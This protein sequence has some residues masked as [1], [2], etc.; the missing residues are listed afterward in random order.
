MI[1]LDT[2]VVAWAANDSKQLS[3]EA[4]SAIRRARRS[5]GLAVSGITVWELALLVSSGK[6]Q[7]YGSVETSLRLLLEG[8]TILPITP[9]I[10]ALTTQ[11]PDD[12]P[13]DPSDRLIGA[14]ARADG[15]TL[16]TR[17]ERIR[18]SPLIRTVW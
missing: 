15:M 10:A 9:E 11:F 8:V 6:L 12:Y 13:R 2:H 7:V 18:R 5:G 14:T 17:N 3:R 1:L 4:A 16:V